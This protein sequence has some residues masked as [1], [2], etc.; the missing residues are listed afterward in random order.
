MTCKLTPS[1]TS[2]QDKHIVWIQRSFFFFFWSNVNSKIYKQ[3]KLVCFEYK[4]LNM[5]QERNLHYITNNE[6][7]GNKNVWEWNLKK[8]EPVG[9]FLNFFSS[10]KERIL[11][12]P[13]Q[14]RRHFSVEDEPKGDISL[15]RNKERNREREREIEMG[16]MRRWIEE[17]NVH[18]IAKLITRLSLQAR[19]I[20]NISN[21]WFVS[22]LVLDKPSYTNSELAMSDSFCFSH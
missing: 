11:L 13:I 15:R 21:V 6:S 7:C 1:F 22:W 10:G 17:R 16:E 8:T 9:R 12:P 14:T 18:G 4:S 20:I 5:K 19:A 3:K 2:I